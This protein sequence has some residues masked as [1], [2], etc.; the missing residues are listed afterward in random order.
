MW[1]LRGACSRSMEKRLGDDEAGRRTAGMLRQALSCS[2]KHTNVVFELGDGSQSVGAHSGV[3][4]SASQ[5]FEVM[6]ESGM[7]EAQEGVI[8]VPAWVGSESLKGLLEWMYLGEWM[9]DHDFCFV[10]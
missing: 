9:C 10:C 8:Q 5:V 2:S 6:L 7:L 3:L 1:D 4:C